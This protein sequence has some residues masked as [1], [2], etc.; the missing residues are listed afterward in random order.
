MLSALASLAL[1][2]PQQKG[3]IQ[4]H[5]ALQRALEGSGV[6]CRGQNMQTACPGHSKVPVGCL[7]GLGP[8]TRKRG[9]VADFFE[10]HI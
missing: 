5:L 8:E 9:H 3:L 4:D 7:R 6:G 2:R 1:P 10:T